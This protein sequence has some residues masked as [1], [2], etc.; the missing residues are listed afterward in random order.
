MFNAVTKLSRIGLTA[1]MAVAVASCGGDSAVRQAEQLYAEA[2]NLKAEGHF[3]Q[4]LTLLDSIDHAYPSA[5]DVRRQ[6]MSL[7]PLLIEQVTN[8]QL[9]IADSLAAVG[10]YRLDSLSAT[11]TL[12]SNPI[13][14]YFVPKAEGR[15]DV[16]SVAGLHA[17]M[18]SDGRFYLV[19]TSP[20]HLRT[21]SVSLTANGQTVSSP[22]VAYDGERNDR[23]GA[24]DVITLIEGECQELGSFVVANVDAPI[25]VTY[26][27]SQSVVRQLSDA[28]KRGIAD[29]FETATLI[30]ERKKQE[31]EKQRLERML[32]TVR[33]QIA[34][35]ATDTVA[36]SDR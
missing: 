9:E 3:E 5:V 7:R 27:G 21:T 31:L 13:E 8:R 33:S 22:Q 16:S 2:Q 34:R 24:N 12:V 1:A 25:S 6:A 36:D 15:V 17:R 19:V 29:L 14:N 26:S 18:S 35:T 32:Q 11:A 10:A 23:S 30:R 4:A 28:Q 20:G